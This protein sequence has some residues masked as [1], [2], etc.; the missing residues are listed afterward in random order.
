VVIV[1]ADNVVLIEASPYNFKEAA[2]LQTM[3][4]QGAYIPHP[5]VAFMVVVGYPRDGT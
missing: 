1:C 4:H 5:E 3:T 2:I